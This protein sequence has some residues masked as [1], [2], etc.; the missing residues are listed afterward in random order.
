[1]LRFQNFR[2]LGH[3]FRSQPRHAGAFTP[4]DVRRYKAALAKPGALTAAI[5]YYRA[6]FRYRH[7]AETGFRP[8]RG[9]ALV[10]WGDRDS[11]LNPHVLDGLPRWAPDARLVRIPDAS[12]W[13]QNDAPE[14]VNHLLLQFLGSL[15]PADARLGQPDST[16]RPSSSR[17]R[18][19]TVRGSSASLCVTNRTVRSAARWSSIHDPAR[20]TVPA[21]SV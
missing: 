18:R 21:S 19:V 4:E 20:P 2:M 9:P 16:T 10:I 8:V 17:S 1:M 3:T 14:A 5:N 12:H 15:P 7:E 11:Y 13:V 6:A